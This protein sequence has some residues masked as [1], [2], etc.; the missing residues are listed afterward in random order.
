MAILAFFAT[1]LFVGL[2]GL[3]LGYFLKSYFDVKNIQTIESR[4]AKIKQQAEHEAG[5][6]ISAAHKQ[7]QELQTRLIKKEQ[8]LE[9]RE[10]VFDVERKGLEGKKHDLEKA[11]EETKQK[12]EQYTV[13]LED[14]A[15]LSKDEIKEHLLGEVEQQYKDAIVKRIDRLERDG[16]EQ[17]DEKAR[18]ILASA[19]HRM[20]NPVENDIISTS[21]VLPDDDTKGKIIGKE[22]R[23]IKAFERTTGVQLVIDETPG[24]IVISSFDPVRRVIAKKTLEKLIEDGRIQPARI[25]QIFEQ[26]SDE[27]EE[28]IKQKGKDAL[29]ECGIKD[30]PDELTSLLG[31]LY[32]RYSYGQ[33][34]L[35]H[36][37]EM[38]KIAGMLAENIGANAYVAKAGALFH[39]IGKALDHKAEGSHVEIG[40]SVLAQYK[41]DEE[42]IKAMQA[43]HEEYPYENVESLLVQAADSISGGR[44]GARSDVAGMYIQKLEGLER[45][46]TDIAGV[47]SAYAIS[48]GREMRVFV[49]PEEVDDY[50][51]HQI[52]KEIA[53]KVEKELKYPG[54]IKIHVIRES[55]I[56]EFAR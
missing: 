39:D 38:A 51:A 15:G 8:H 46:A 13:R 40:R 43:H 11:L 10:V 28:L 37:V 45:I 32:F 4:I 54:E 22:G 3:L 14:M 27:I 9:S 56:V 7:T 50:R 5:E 24:V 26:V 52:A 31:S 25:E 42:I 30:I 23:N 53:E 20:S 19:I 55:R 12:A 34:V 29:D 17:Y 6:I 48:A 21:F 1:L 18:G 2:L 33:N 41:I 35:Q 16:K 47:E 49:K 36:S 44:P